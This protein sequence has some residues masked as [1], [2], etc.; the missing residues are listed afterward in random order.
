MLIMKFLYNTSLFGIII[1]S[2][3]AFLGFGTLFSHLD[4]SIGLQALTAAF[5]ALFIILSTKFLMDKEDAISLKREKEQKIFDQSIIDYRDI[6]AF[7]YGI[8]IKKQ[9]TQS[10]I[11]KLQSTYLANFVLLGSKEAIQVLINF[12]KKLQDIYNNNFQ[13]Y[14]NEEGV[15]IELNELK[16]TT[17]N[18]NELSP[19]EELLEIASNFSVIIRMDLNHVDKFTGVD[20]LIKNSFESLDA[21]EKEV[22]QKSKSARIA[23][24]KSDF[25]KRKN[26]ISE[27]ADILDTFI[28]KL[29]TFC[30]LTPKYTASQIS[31]SK[32]DKKS[33][34]KN[35]LYIQNVING[36]CRFEFAGNHVLKSDDFF[37]KE[38]TNSL[39]N[40]QP[41]VKFSP[42]KSTETTN[43]KVLSLH[44]DKIMLENDDNLNTLNE[45]IKRYIKKFAKKT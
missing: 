5:G 4:A 19:Y 26:I 17:N 8:L 37:E 2:I 9:L 6:L 38:L 16:E 33:Y 36:E 1:I 39:I 14:I 20:D 29:E 22:T 21:L 15:V 23:I 18:K 11:N 3:A 12:N 40:F 7:I 24:S 35:L 45:A 27:D 30:E 25:I 43:L 32:L 34:N 31:F 10:D 42:S 28:N 13:D 41:K 44:I